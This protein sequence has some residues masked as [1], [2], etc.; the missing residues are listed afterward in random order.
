V[1]LA[2]TRCRVEE[3]AAHDGW[4][5][6]P[7]PSCT[8]KALNPRSAEPCLRCAGAGSLLWNASGFYVRYDEYEEV[9]GVSS[10]LSHE[11]RCSPAQEHQ[12]EGLVTALIRVKIHQDDLAEILAIDQ[13]EV[14]RILRSLTEKRI[15]HRDAAAIADL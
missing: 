8:G 1:L 3:H 6:R 15:R 4:E 14:E 9:H 11:V 12:L 10:M 5:K 7:C 2:A 13:S